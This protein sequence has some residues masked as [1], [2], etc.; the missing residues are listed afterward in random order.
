MPPA[1][2]VSLVA[3]IHIDAHPQLM[4]ED[5]NPAL[6]LTASGG[7]VDQLCSMWFCRL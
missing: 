4:I 1:F 7:A 3:N 6:V 5:T 2:L